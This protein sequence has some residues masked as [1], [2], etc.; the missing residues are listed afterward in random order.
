MG[1][2]HIRSGS[3]VSVAGSNVRQTKTGTPRRGQQFG[4]SEKKSH[5]IRRTEPG[6][7]VRGLVLT[8]QGGRAP[9]ALPGDA[10]HMHPKAAHEHR[11]YYMYG[12][13]DHG[14][15]LVNIVRKDLMM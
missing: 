11:L 8:C 12:T 14:R 1:Y 13:R 10:L 7:K 2:V 5:L 4:I 9:A 6:K 15:Q 3:N